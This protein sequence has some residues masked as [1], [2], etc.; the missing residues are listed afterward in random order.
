[1]T[2]ANTLSPALQQ[3]GT[4]ADWTTRMEV[5]VDF[6]RALGEHKLKAAQAE[7]AW[8]EAMGQY[9]VVDARRLVV[10]QLQRSMRQ[11]HREEARFARW[12]WQVDQRR[13][14]ID[15]LVSGRRPSAASWP[16]IRAAY[17]WF[18][19]RAL[20]ESGESLFEITIP[21][22]ARSG[23]NFR[24]ATLPSIACAD[25]PADLS[26]ALGMME[27]LLDERYVP[28]PGSAA[29]RVIVQL[30]RAM[31][32]PA[33]ATVARLRAELDALRS[34]TYETWKPLAILGVEESRVIREIKDAGT[35]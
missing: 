29:H 20:L 4:F 9:A 25:L 12:A 22:A 23:A 7:V 26:T 3:V 1:M 18:A 14:R 21:S 2:R 16:G 32:A 8:A 30:F 17:H 34:S 10:R 24:N 5:Y 19:S 33:Q 13:R 35:R 28:R 15:I 27:W 6:I 31:N 11:L